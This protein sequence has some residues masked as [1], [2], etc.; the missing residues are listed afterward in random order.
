MSSPPVDPSVARGGDARP[1]PESRRDVPGAAPGSG[2]AHP[3]STDAS[4]RHPPSRS[5][6]PGQGSYGGWTG[7]DTSAQPTPKARD[8]DELA[9]A[10]VERLHGFADVDV[11]EVRI[12]VE[13]GIAR[14]DGRVA[15]A[16][17]R[18]AIEA[19]VAEVL[20]VTG[21]DNR[22]AVRDR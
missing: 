16:G 14:L 17:A 22:L 13:D 7:Q 11:S 10:L 1:S 6:D 18:D 5:A 2:G 8:D 12:E 21:V 15:D 9:A 4:G 19:R 3:D 20:G